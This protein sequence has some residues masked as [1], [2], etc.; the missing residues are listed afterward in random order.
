[1]AKYLRGKGLL[2]SSLPLVRFGFRVMGKSWND[3][4]AWML[5]TLERKNSLDRIFKHY[6]TG[7]GKDRGLYDWSR[8][9]YHAQFLM[10]IGL[11]PH[12]RLLDFGCGYG[13]TAIALLGYLEPGNYIG[14]DLSKRRI[15]MAKEW[16][17]RERLADRRPTFLTINDNSLS[18]LESGGIDYIWTYSVFTHMPEAEMV[19]ILRA[20]DRVLAPGGV[21]VFNYSEAVG[22]QLEQPSIKDYRYPKEQILRIISE[23]GYESE[24]RADWDDD[25]E[26]GRKSP[27]SRMLLL[28]RRASA[29]HPK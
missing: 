6:P 24:K 2:W 9:E 8:G 3:F 18:Y 26:D 1:M 23:A 28:T 21:F 5:N 22:D 4:Y 15:E 20:A 10:R 13:R 29:G 11:K 14:A 12:H 27:V 25:L 17:E 16:V 7:T 19:A